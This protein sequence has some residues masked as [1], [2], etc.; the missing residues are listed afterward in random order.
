MAE[1]YFG[2]RTVL[3]LKLQLIQVKVSIELVPRGRSRG[4]ATHV[5]RSPL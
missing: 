5:V 1:A 3:F 2:E 4:D